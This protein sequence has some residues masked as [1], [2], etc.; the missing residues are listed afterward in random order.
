MSTWIASS[1]ARPRVSP[2]AEL[3]QAFAALRGWLV[4]V[5]L[6]SGLI[7][8][9][10][11]TGSLFML[12]VYD[13]VLTS[14]SVPT[15]VALAVI[16][17]LLYAFQGILDIIR[18]RL[19]VRMGSRVDQ[20]LGARVYAVTLALPL[21]GG[22]SGDGLQPLRDLDTIRAF[23][24][25]QGP[26][27]ILDLPWMPVYLALVFALHPALGL[28]ASAGALLLVALTIAT[29]ILSRGPARRSQ[30]EAVRRQALAVAG[31]RNAEVL[32]A[33]GFGHRLAA[34]WLGVNARHLAA[35][36]QA[37]DVTGGL[38]ATS[39]VL[40]ALLQSALLAAGAWLTIAGELSGGAMI[41][42]SIIASRALA[43]IELAI[44]NWKSFLGGR[45]SRKRLA[46]LLAAVPDGPDPMPLPAPR[47]DL[48]VEG[49]SVAPPGATRPMV[50]NV[51]FQLQAGQGLG[52]IGPSAAGKS[53]L[54]RALVGAWPAM[55][56]A[57]RLD[58]AA[59]E[60][61][62]PAALGRH[63]GYLPQDIELF[64]G[65]VAENI[66]RFDEATEPA[67]IIA[68]AQA[69]GLHETILH[70]PEGYSTRIGEGGS[71][72]SAGQRQRLGLARALYGDPFLVVLDEPNSNL[73]AEGEAA[74][75]R[76][77]RGVRERGGILIVVAH[78]PSAIAAVDLV[79]IMAQGMLQAFGPK[80]EVLR[81][82]VQQSGATPHPSGLAVVGE[83]GA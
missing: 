61:W 51:S 40:R 1:T 9:L 35:Q 30:G 46:T 74:L 15:L 80:E 29:E 38:S 66:A 60:Q 56:G 19:L 22:R 75:T 82:N 76:A 77:I 73:D 81:K 83:P 41:A 78:R 44:A 32:R 4:A 28:L 3:G 37:S 65:T 16:A 45:E 50:Q 17:A 10:A 47:R 6:F 13:R 31:Q 67:A 43:P 64:D 71:A 21:R 2:T 72:L 79:G 12:Q 24:A 34:R 48:S 69:A 11:L 59:L 18:S 58:G 63:I 26:V 23:L 27:A 20:I 57:V 8:L 55:R 70:L 68:A 39:K 5:A 49:L 14:R 36:E 7:N 25:G 52:L 62:D 53:S 33:M 42:S 54:V